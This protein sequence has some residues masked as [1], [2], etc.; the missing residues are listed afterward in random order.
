MIRWTE[1]SRVTLRRSQTWDPRELEGYEG[2]V[3]GAWMDGGQVTVKLDCIAYEMD[4]HY[5]MIETL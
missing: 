5:S 3:T 2:T 1:G 4:F